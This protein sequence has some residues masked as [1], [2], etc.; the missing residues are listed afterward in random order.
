MCI[1]FNQ[2][3]ADQYHDLKITQKLSTG[4]TGYHSANYVVLTGDISSTLD[5]LVITTTTYQSHMDQLMVTIKNM[6][7][8]KNIL[9][10]QIKKFRTNV[11][12]E[13][14]STR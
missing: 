7:E 11:F 6:K 10:D 5:N 3:F 4:Q 12:L 2:L 8:T 9:E 1:G 14:R 13:A